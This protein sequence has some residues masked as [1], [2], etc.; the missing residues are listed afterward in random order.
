MT[1][2]QKNGKTHTFAEHEAW[3]VGSDADFPESFKHYLEEGRLQKT[4]EGYA[5]LN[6]TQAKNGV[7]LFTVPKAVKGDWLAAACPP[8]NR[9]FI[10]KQNNFEKSYHLVGE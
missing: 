1:I 8:H 6:F 7:D 5:V 2:I 4:A 3:Q 9:L 10:V